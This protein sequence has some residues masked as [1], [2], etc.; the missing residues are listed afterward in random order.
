MSCDRT[1]L[2]LVGFHFG[3]VEGPE[4]DA[5]EAHLVTCLDCVKRYVLLKRGIELAESGPAPSD[6]GLARLRAAVANEV[7]G[8]VARARA[9]WE[10]PLAALAAMVVVFSAASAVGLLSKDEGSPPHSLPELHRAP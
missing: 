7:K 4:R 3:E 2:D 5:V 6:L 9:K 8:P 1:E 10:R